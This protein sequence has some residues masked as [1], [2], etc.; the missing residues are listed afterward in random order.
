MLAPVENVATLALVYR[1]LAQPF[2]DSTREMSLLGKMGADALAGSE[3]EWLLAEA[4]EQPDKLLPLVAELSPVDP[5]RA[6]ALLH[7][8][9]PGDGLAEAG[10]AWPYRRRWDEI[11]AAM[12]WLEGEGLTTPREAVD[13]VAATAFAIGSIAQMDD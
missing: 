4:M 3:H 2:G 7:A 13:A 12:R 1:E 6:E 11:E 8:F 9:P 10:W 5:L